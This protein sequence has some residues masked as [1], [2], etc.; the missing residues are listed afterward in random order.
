MRSLCW[1]AR[2]RRCTLMAPATSASRRSTSPRFT[3]RTLF[4]FIIASFSGYFCRINNIITF[5]AFFLFVKLTFFWRMHFPA[6]INVSPP[7]ISYIFLSFTI[8]SKCRGNHKFF[9]GL[10][11]F[12]YGLA[13]IISFLEF[14]S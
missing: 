2:R 6:S 7:C 9:G 12:F 8:L 4:S 3:L 10:M 11:M 13:L 1:R 14:T 5:A